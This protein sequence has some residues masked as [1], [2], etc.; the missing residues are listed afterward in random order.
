M[1][2]LT[3]AT[4]TRTAEGRNQREARRAAFEALPPAQRVQL[5]R[6]VR[7]RVRDALA[8]LFRNE[9]ELDSIFT[10]LCATSPGRTD[11]DRKIG[12]CSDSDD[13][14]HAVAGMASFNDHSD[15]DHLEE[16]LDTLDEGALAQIEARLVL[17]RVEETGA[18]DRR[19]TDAAPVPGEES[20]A[21]G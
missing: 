15:V 10:D 12:G 20:L 14:A 3:A 4:E 6:E 9:A 13:L 16:C 19:R 5:L 7:D 8:V 2:E 1:R 18:G 17:A 11:L 21:Q